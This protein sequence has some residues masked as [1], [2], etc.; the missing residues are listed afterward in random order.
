MM[1]QAAG[2]VYY[3]DEAPA[4][5][6]YYDGAGTGAPRLY[7]KIAAT[8]I[9]ANEVKLHVEGIVN[10]VEQEIVDDTLPMAATAPQIAETSSSAITLSFDVPEGMQADLEIDGMLYENV[11]SPFI[12][13]SLNPD[14]EHT[15]RLRYTNTLG[16]G[17]FSEQVSAKT[18]LDPYR[19]VISGAVATA[20][21]YE[22]IPGDSYPPQNLVD[23]DLASQWYSNWDDQKYY[24][25][26]KII[27]IDL[28]MAYQLDK[29]EY[30]NDG[31]S[32]ILD[33]EILISKDGVH[34]EQVD[35]SVWEKQYQ[36]D[37]EFDG[38]IAR[39]VRIISHDQRFNSGNEIRIYKVDGT[40]GFSEADC[41]GDRILNHDDLTFLKNY[42]G[43]DQNNQRLWN[44]VKEAD[45]SCN[46]IIDAYDLMFVA[47][48]LDGGVRD[49]QDEVSGMIS[50]TADKTSVKKG[51][52]V[53]ISVNTH[54]FVNVYALNFELLLDA[55]KLSSAVCPD[56]VCTA[57]SPFTA[58][59]FTEGMLDYSKSGET[60]IEGK[61][62]V[63]FYGAFS[64]VGDNGPLQGDGVIATIELTALQDIEEIDMILND[65]Q[66]ISSGGT[67]A[68]A[69]WKDDGGEEG[70]GTDPGE[71]EKPGEG[72]D[73][74]KPGDDGDTGVN[75]QQGMMLALFA[76]AGASAVIAYRRRQR[77]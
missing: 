74:P 25:E 1:A 6:A 51:D 55:E 41:N 27:D 58:G 11:T 13:D 12:H 31:T 23:D 42:M 39:Y 33:H 63:R 2:N 53:T 21:S 69:S 15:Y 57:D 16:S 22:D 9:T 54:D 37:Y 38:R 47:S 40:D 28:Q 62:H 65:V 20:N 72:E 34:Y 48:R 30:I 50:F 56:N 67:I 59:E 4:N 7:V 17:E 29:L 52:T 61:D 36:N 73:T 10:R 35:A 26:P 18:D 3:Y 71:G 75:T 66:V 32:Q 49:P 45:F 77:Q 70:P 76:A 5:S 64:F 46:G 19:N 14:E 44:Q 24:T 43:V 60:Q 68:D 8:D